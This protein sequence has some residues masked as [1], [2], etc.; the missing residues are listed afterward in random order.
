M[1]SFGEN[2]CKWR[3][4]LLSQWMSGAVV[5]DY[6]C[7]WWISLEFIFLELEKDIFI[8]SLEFDTIV[9]YCRWLS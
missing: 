7:V 6:K 5:E 9:S 2:P 4:F 8:E 1:S 3:F